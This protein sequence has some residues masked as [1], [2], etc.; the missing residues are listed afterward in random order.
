[1][2]GVKDVKIE[3]TLDES[4]KKSAERQ[5]RHRIAGIHEK[6]HNSLK[7]IKAVFINGLY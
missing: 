2:V 3:E 4:G 7:Q 6:P 5:K 1:M